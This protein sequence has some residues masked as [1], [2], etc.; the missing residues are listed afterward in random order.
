MARATDVFESLVKEHLKNSPTLKEA[1][2][3]ASDE[4]EEKAD[5]RLYNSIE[6]YNVVRSRRKKKSRT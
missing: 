4:F 1:F 3:R 6:S 5:F 2:N